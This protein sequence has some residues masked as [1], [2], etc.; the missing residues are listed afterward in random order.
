MKIVWIASMVI[1]ALALL[2]LGYWIFV[3]QI[4]NPRVVRELIENPNGERAGRVML[5]TL[6]SGRRIPVNFY[7]EDDMVYAGADGSWWKELVG[8]GFPV[9]VLVR[10]ETLQGT[11]RTVLDDP[12]YTTQIFKKLRP[13]AIE[14][15]G[16]LVEIR[17]E[18][19]GE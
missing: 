3:V 13:N 1:A 12:V 9:S 19:A 14:G 6:P 8:D 4:G 18:N 16:R 17:I 5:L 15:F 10:G 11:A 2:V 7:R